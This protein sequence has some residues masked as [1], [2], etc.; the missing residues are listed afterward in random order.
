MANVSDQR[1]KVLNGLMKLLSNSAFTYE[2]VVKKKPKGI[3]IIHE[4][5][6]EDMNA[7]VEN[8]RKKEGV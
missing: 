8:S 2:L 4:V 6:E 1:E 3:R 5:T 7:M